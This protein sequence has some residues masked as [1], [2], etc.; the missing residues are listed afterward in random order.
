MVSADGHSFL[1]FFRLS[2]SLF[3]FSLHEGRLIEE[4]IKSP[5]D[6][7]SVNLLEVSV[8]GHEYLA[9]S[10]HWC[11]SIK[12]MDLNKHVGWIKGN[13]NGHSRCEFKN[14]QNAVITPFSG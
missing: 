6:H 8:A 4:E 11:Q 1:S 7:N 13:N 9:L 3:L 2:M 12:L 14:I 5:C 10:C